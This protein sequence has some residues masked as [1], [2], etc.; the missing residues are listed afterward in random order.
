MVVAIAEVAAHFQKMQD[1]LMLESAVE[2]W[3]MWLLKGGA[4][5][6]QGGKLIV[7]VARL[8]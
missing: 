3:C 7:G 4:H 8:L 6:D 2:G 5:G 1:M